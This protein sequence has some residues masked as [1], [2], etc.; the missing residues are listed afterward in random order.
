M[1]KCYTELTFLVEDHQANVHN[2]NIIRDIYFYNVRCVT[3]C[4]TTKQNI[5]T[6]TVMYHKLRNAFTDFYRKCE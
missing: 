3:H 4:N 2:S 6:A 5:E 1:T